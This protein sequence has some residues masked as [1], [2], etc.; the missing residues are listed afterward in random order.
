MFCDN[1]APPADDTLF[2]WALKFLCNK[3]SENAVNVDVVI[4]AAPYIGIVTV[5][6]F[7][8]IARLLYFP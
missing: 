6:S 8:V 5:K 3:G 2:I 7:L 1:V 4:S